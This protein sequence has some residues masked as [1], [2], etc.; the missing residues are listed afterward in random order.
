M[1][2][3]FIKSLCLGS[4]GAVFLASVGCG[5]KYHNVVDPC[6]PDRYVA[7]A[8]QATK[9]NIAPQVQ[10]GHILDQTVWNSYFEP[11]TAT[12]NKMGIYRID[13]LVRRRPT[14][15]GTV[16]LQ[17]AHDMDEP[18]DPKD[19]GAFVSARQKLDRDRLESVNGYLKAA[20]AGRQLAFNVELHDPA[21]ADIAGQPSLTPVGG[22]QVQG[23]LLVTQQ[24][25]N[26][27][28]VRPPSSVFGTTPF[29]TMIPE[30]LQQ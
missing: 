18:F 3:G 25:L 22:G 5:P 9:D 14:P 8:Q 29:G 19:P 2:N 30:R 10:N 7:M 6:Y 12:L 21:T 27:A 13:Y 26:A 11:G 23:I 15:D 4:L 20:S 17:T 28:P 1:M 16:Y 24:Q